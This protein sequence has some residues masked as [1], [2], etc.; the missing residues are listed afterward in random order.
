MFPTELETDRLRLVRCCRKNISARELYEYMRVDAPHMD[1]I[2]EHVVWE[3]HRTVK[4]SEEYLEELEA[5]WESRKQ[6]TYIVYPREGEADAGEFAGLTNTRF[7]WDRKTAGL[8][9]WLRKPF[10][11]RGYSG[12]RAAALMELAF[13]DLDLEVVGASHQ[14]GNEQSRRAVEKYIEAHGGQYDGLLRNWIAKDDEVRDL[15]RYTVTKEQYEEAT[16]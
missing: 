9:I 11:G 14:P 5:E 1:E 7:A 10:W 15:R 3:P 8:G 12:E 6:A 13:E 4:E 2:S 16:G